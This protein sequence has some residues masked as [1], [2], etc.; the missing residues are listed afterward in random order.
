M[1]IRVKRQRRNAAGA[2]ATRPPLLFSSLVVAGVVEA[3]RFPS[4]SP[5]NFTSVID[6]SCPARVRTSESPL[7][8]APLAPSLCIYIELPAK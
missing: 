2:N 6:G 3:I 1:R 7:R 5:Y 4:S 8:R